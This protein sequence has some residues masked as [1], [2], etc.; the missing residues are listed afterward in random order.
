MVIAGAEKMV[1]QVSV[2]L[3]GELCGINQLLLLGEALQGF[4]PL[5]GR[6]LWNG[7]IKNVS[8]QLQSGFRPLVGRAL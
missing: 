1:S 3:W 8:K 6:A 4:R 5:V 7:D 2:P